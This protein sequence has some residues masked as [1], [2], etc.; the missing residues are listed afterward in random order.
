MK[1]PE[2]PVFFLSTTGRSNSV[3][4]SGSSP[5]RNLAQRH[6]LLGLVDET[7]I[8]VAVGLGEPVVVVHRRQQP[9]SGNGESHT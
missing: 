9:L 8:D 4:V 6:P 5:L 2:T 1:G 7:A 3:T